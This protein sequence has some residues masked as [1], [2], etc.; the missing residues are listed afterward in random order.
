[1]I[2]PEVVKNSP[3]IPGLIGSFLAALTGPQRDL[4]TRGIGFLAGFAVAVFFTDIVLDKL[5]L[6]AKTYSG[7]VGF[8]LGFFG[9]TIADAL[10]R[11]FREVDWASIVRKKIG[12]GE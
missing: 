3:F 1:M 12:G 2:E 11:V 8:A 4:W 6:P 5:A 9:L 10:L 7:G